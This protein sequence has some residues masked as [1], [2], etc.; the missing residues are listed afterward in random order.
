[1]VLM[2]MAC[3]ST[4]Q[5][6]WDVGNQLRWRSFVCRPRGRPGSRE[7]AATQRTVERIRRSPRTVGRIPGREA[8]L[9]DTR[10]AVKAQLGDTS[11][12]TDVRAVLKSELEHKHAALE[13]E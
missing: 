12:A 3:L 8:Q 9:G 11:T 2:S 10:A 6:L 5:C 1:M 7:A 4:T 13:E